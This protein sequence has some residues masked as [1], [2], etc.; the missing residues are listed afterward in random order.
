MDFERDEGQIDDLKNQTPRAAKYSTSTA[1]ALLD[2][3]G[4]LEEKP[5]NKNRQSDQLQLYQL[6][7]EQQKIGLVEPT[8]IVAANAMY[9]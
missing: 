4:N 7:D 6:L 3:T 8:T 5:V 9:L 2:S 1:Q